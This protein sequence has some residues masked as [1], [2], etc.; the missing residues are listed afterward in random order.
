ML[1]R[2]YNTY[3]WGTASTCWAIDILERPLLHCDSTA[4][5]IPQSSWE[6]KP[7]I[8]PAQEWTWDVCLRNHCFHGPRLIIRV[9][10]SEDFPLRSYKGKSILM[11]LSFQ[12]SCLLIFGSFS[13]L[14][15]TC[16]CLGKVSSFSSVQSLS[17]VQLFATP[18]TTACQ[19]SLSVTNSWSFLKLMSIT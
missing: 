9:P 13:F 4:S 6:G 15:G 16:N 3:R 14:E 10:S 11:A 5:K 2:L 19:A 18:W 1:L 7:S 12:I 17:P 8:V